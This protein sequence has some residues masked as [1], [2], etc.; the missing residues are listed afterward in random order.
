M[1][2]KPPRCELVLR[3]G[4]IPCQS[5]VCA[6]IPPCPWTD[7]T[8]T[9]I[10]VH[11]KLSCSPHSPLCVVLFGVVGCSPGDRLAFAPVCSGQGATTRPCFV[12]LLFGVEYEVLAVD[13]P[14]HGPD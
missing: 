5:P 9:L 10:T 2:L 12:G 1:K 11:P 8:I 3:M 14:M 13:Q 7:F 4:R 6:V